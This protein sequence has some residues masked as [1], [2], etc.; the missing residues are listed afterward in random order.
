ML[1]SLLISFF[2][3]SCLSTWKCWCFSW[4]NVSA[5]TMVVDRK[6][7]KSTSSAIFGVETA[8]KCC[9]LKRCADRVRN[10]NDEANLNFSPELYLLIFSLKLNISP[11][12][13]KTTEY[14][15][16]SFLPLTNL[17]LTFVVFAC[18]ATTRV[19]MGFR[20]K[21][22]GFSTGLYPVYATLY[23][24]LWCGRTDGHVTVTS[25]PKFLGLTDYQICLVMVLRYYWGISLLTAAVLRPV[26][27][28]L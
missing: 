10:R 17:F 2:V 6:K 9:K 19:T 5:K 13:K 27:A 4:Q 22:T 21:N 11:S 25:L 8:A 1:I 12:T 20:A 15:F 16:N 18:V 3:T 7:P 14:F 23:W 24:C 26:A 28:T